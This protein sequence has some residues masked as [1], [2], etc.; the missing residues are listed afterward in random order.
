[1]EPAQTI[2][3]ETPLQLESSVAA[4]AAGYNSCCFSLSGMKVAIE[5]VYTSTALCQLFLCGV[6]IQTTTVL[7]SRLDDLIL[8]K[9]A[10]YGCLRGE[11]D[12][13]HIQ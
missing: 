11:I 7:R 8:E 3:V 4:S 12:Q 9:A 1:M 6:I 10:P 13:C 2:F 5:N